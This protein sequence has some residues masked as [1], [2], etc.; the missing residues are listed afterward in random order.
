MSGTLG[1]ILSINNGKQMKRVEEGVNLL[2]NGG[3][4]TYR[5]NDKSNLEPDKSYIVIHKQNGLVS[6]IQKGQNVCVGNNA[7]YLENKD[8][9]Q[10]SL[11]KYLYFVFVSMPQ[12]ITQHLHGSV[13]PTLRKSDISNIGIRPVS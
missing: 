7:F 11:L 5:T 4:K 9:T 12:I 1:S 10:P 13:Q 3:K 8:L 2:Y 6:W